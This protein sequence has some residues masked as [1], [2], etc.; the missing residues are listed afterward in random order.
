L[1]QIIW[2]TLGGHPRTLVDLEL[3]PWD[4]GKRKDRIEVRLQCVVCAGQVALTDA[5]RKIGEYWQGACHRYARVKCAHG[6]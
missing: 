6:H 3:Q 4:E 2:H 1:E 5:Q